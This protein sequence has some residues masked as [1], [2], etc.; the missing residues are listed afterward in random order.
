MRIAFP[1]N[2]DRDD[3]ALTYK[4]MRNGVN[5]A[6]IYTA[7]VDSSEWQRPPLGF[8]DTGLTPGHELQL[9]AT[10]HGRRRQ[11]GLG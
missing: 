10:G 8:T 3:R 2:W 6:P 7:T 11:P 5:N 1:A 9:P 4:I